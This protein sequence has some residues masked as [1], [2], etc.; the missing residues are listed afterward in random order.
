M[1]S[2]ILFQGIERFFFGFGPVLETSTLPLTPNGYA[3]LYCFLRC[4][5]TTT[6]GQSYV[7]ADC[8]EGRFHITQ[9]IS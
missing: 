9:I 5:A 8:R 1:G 7:A 2:T 4:V 3:L 6:R